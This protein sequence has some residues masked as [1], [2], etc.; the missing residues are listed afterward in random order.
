MSKKDGRRDGLKEREGMKGKQMN[1]GER[2]SEMERAAAR[3]VKVLVGFVYVHKGVYVMLIRYYYL[4]FVHDKR[5]DL[6][7]QGYEIDEE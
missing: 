7:K 3:R 1:G 2:G 4:V 5:Y 6:G